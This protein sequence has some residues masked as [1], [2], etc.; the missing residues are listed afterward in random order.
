MRKIWIS[1]IFL[2]LLCIVFPAAAEQTE[3]ADA[4]T[5]LIYMCGSDLES[6]YG[7]GTANLE[8]IASVEAPADASREI[9][10]VIG[11]PDLAGS[12]SSA[13]TVNVL[14]ET[15][16]A[17]AWHAEALG[18]NVRTDVLQYWEYQPA[19]NG[20]QGSFALKTERP[21]ASMA[22]PATLTDFIRWGAE[23]YP[24]EKYMLVL[25]NHGGG[26]ARGILIDELFGGEYMTLNLLHK[27]LEDGG[28]HLEAVLF[29]ACLMANIETASAIRE[30]ADWMI[31]SEELVAGKGTAF[32]EWLQELYYVPLANGRLLG[33]WICDT[34]FIKYANSEDSQAQDTLTWSVID[35]NKAEEMEKSFDRVYEAMCILCEKKP[36]MLVAF[37]NATHY[38]M[39]FGTGIESMF[40][41]GG[42]MFDPVLR[43]SSTSEI[44]YLMQEK[45]A[46]AVDYS[47]R[48]IGRASA[49]GI[50][51]C[52][53]TDFTIKELDVYALNCPSPH[54]LALLDAISP[55][56]AP[57]W[58]YEKA[59]KLPEMTEEGVFQ[60]QI[61]KKI[62]ENGTPAFAVTAGEMN[63]SMVKY[64]LYQKDE[65]TGETVK[66]GEIPLIYDTEAD[67]FRI[68]DLTS[69]PSIDGNLCQIEL[70]NMVK[71]G[72]YNLVYNIPVTV[73][74]TTMNMRCNYLWDTHRFEIVGL[75]ENYD[76]D[77]SQFN[78]NIQ[79]LSQVAG[80]EFSLLYEI[81]SNNL[82]RNFTYLS[83]PP[84][85]LYRAMR[86]EEI[87]LPA[88]T[89]YLQY[90]VMDAFM[91]EMRLDPVELFWNGQEIK[92]VGDPWE[93]TMVLS[94]LSYYTE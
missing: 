26:S 55:W 27:A 62:W 44:Q 70:Q 71:I 86:V 67:L 72:D 81:Q 68:Y 66:L 19:A 40:D 7:F 16:G 34:A 85:M 18:M 8:E 60:I 84:M 46:E 80:Q 9:L 45:M 64:K 36:D 21:L 3:E 2:T 59:E 37:A 31:A 61:E 43:A 42:L 23:S 20:Q 24:A 69:W 13:R 11:M 50:S 30:Y 47:V 58:V 75:W 74:A 79:S 39:E 32:G 90:T 52:N 87:Q 1:M 76:S 6:K 12:G 78:R 83:S 33:R 41:V 22:D 63:V 77:S 57:E 29:D 54:Y 92:I 25:W 94:P 5:V 56:D 38:Y 35:L 82:K 15:G 53:A 17:K 73:N 48:G 88:G 65:L 4:W 49:R 28:T 93:G 10:D 89:Y 51:F 14:I 91:R